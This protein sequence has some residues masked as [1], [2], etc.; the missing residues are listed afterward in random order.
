MK[1]LVE[2]GAA[3][4]GISR[5]LVRRATP[6]VAILGYHNI[7]PDGEHPVGDI[8]LHV[9]QRR[10]SDQL[11]LVLETH[12]VVGLEEID[13]AHNMSERPK[14]VLTFDDAYRGTIIAGFEE[15]RRRSLPATV[16]VPPGLL[17]TEGFWWD[18][19]AAPGGHPLDARLR[20]HAHGVELQGRQ[21][22]VLEFARAEGLPLTDLPDWA[23]ASDAE[24]LLGAVRA[25][26]GVTLGAHTWSHPNLAVLSGDE[27]RDEIQRCRR[28]LKESEIATADWLAY[29]YGLYDER[30]AGITAEIHE[31]ALLVEGG[32]AQVRGKWYGDSVRIPRLQ[33]PHHLSVNGLSIRLS[34]VLRGILAGT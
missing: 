17:G 6:S 33:V 10:F 19:L 22:A 28:W 25:S 32:M 16:F 34:G 1:E 24:E 27:V 11:D 7:I 3:R 4:S 18:R 2:M 26:P 13:V 14:V 21:Q 31:G 12:D 23:A 20:A 30:V 9:P 5:A 8:A 15:L 29:P